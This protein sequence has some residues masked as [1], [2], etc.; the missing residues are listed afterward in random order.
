MEWPHSERLKK[1]WSHSKQEREE[2]HGVPIKGKRR[3]GK[4][5]GR[6]RDTAGGGKRFTGPKRR[7]RC[8]GG[9]RNDAI[10]STAVR[11]APTWIYR[12]K[13]NRCGLG[14]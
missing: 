7:E 5:T 1:Q 10:T 9:D 8:R 11:E 4:A 2:E 13:K 6:G 12:P 14:R 3:K